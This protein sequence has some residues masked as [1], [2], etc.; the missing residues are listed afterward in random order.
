MDNNYRYRHEIKYRI[1]G[2][3][4]HILRGRFA[5]VMEHDEHAK[6]GMYR[7]TSLYFDDVYRTAYK[8]KV[9]G[10]LKRKK[11][12]VR[13]YGHDTDGFRTEPSLIRL[14]EKVKHENVG[15]KKTTVLT[16]EQYKSLLAGDFGIFAGEEYA[17]TA[18]GDMFASD[19]AAH[20]SPAVIVDYL[21]EAYTCRAGNV[22]VTFD[23]KIS[24]CTS[25]YDIFREDNV[26]C[27]VMPDNDIVLEVKYDSFMPDYVRQ[28]LSGITA[29]QES[30]SKFILC[31][32]RLRGNYL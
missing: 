1:N 11:Y 28:L 29:Q 19:R 2:G 24:A 14:E 9:N 22:R 12:R 13:A 17:D 32:D 25:G 31:S 16:M 27:T 30:V 23:M 21:R 3:T 18:A 8:D 20:L 5:A 4:Y 15:F 7:V 6:S 26:F 10:A